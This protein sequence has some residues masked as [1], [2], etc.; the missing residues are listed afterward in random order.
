MLITTTLPHGPHRGP[1]GK[2]LPTPVFRSEETD[3]AGL[4][5]QTCRQFGPPASFMPQ[6]ERWK[7]RPWKGDACSAD[8]CGEYV[9][10]GPLAPCG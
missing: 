5:V 8:T 6:V 9:H 10:P 2:D 1:D 4:D 3:E 7:N